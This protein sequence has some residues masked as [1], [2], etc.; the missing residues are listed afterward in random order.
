MAVPVQSA[1]HRLI[2]DIDS[3]EQVFYPKKDFLNL[4][5]RGCH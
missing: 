4:S 2:L 1:L 3:K 5:L